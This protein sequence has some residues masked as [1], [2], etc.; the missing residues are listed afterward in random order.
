MASNPTRPTTDLVLLDEVAARLGLTPR[1]VK[2]LHREDDL[3]LHRLANGR[4]VAFWSEIEAWVKG[5]Q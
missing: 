4:L 2:R 1:T 3:P 5:C